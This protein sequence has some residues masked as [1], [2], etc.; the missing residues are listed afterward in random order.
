MTP[1]P[2]SALENLLFSNSEV[3]ED[4]L[5]IEVIL[6][7]EKMVAVANTDPERHQSLVGQVVKPIFSDEFSVACNVIHGYLWKDPSEFFEQGYLRSCTFLK[8]ALF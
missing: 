8:N 7:V 6:A 5:G 3:T 1:H 4:Y 2:P